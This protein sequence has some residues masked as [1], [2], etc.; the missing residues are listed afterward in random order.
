MKRSKLTAAGEAATE[1]ILEVFRLNGRLLMSGDRLVAPLGLTSARWQVLGAIA[2]AEQPQPVA[3][4][5][6]S[7][8]LNR[9]GVQRLV[10]E[11]I[12]DGLVETRPNPHHRRAHHVVLTKRGRDAYEAAARLQAPWVTDLVKGLSCDEIATALRV[13]ATLRARL[14]QNLKREDGSE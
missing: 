6:R 3:W 8:G 4:L 2:L 9:Q 1:F 14:E 7:M 5:A 10:N 13:A 12:E 11:M